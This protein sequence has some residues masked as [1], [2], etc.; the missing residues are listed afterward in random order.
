MKHKVHCAQSETSFAPAPG[1]PARR[2][3]MAL[4]LNFLS[5]GRILE[6]AL[7]VRLS[8]RKLA[9]AA[10]FICLCLGLGHARLVNA[11]VIFDNGGP[12]LT[13]FGAISDS[14]NTQV[15]ED[16]RLSAGSNI[17]TDVHWWGGYRFDESTPATDNFTI[18]I[19]ATNAVTNLPVLTPLFEFF[20]GD[21]GRTAIGTDTNPSTVYEYW[22]NIPAT[23]LDPDTT[24]WLSIVNTTAPFNPLDDWF[25]ERAENSGSLA[26]LT[27][28]FLNWQANSTAELA[29]N[30]TGNVPEPS[31][32]ALLALGLAGITFARRRNQ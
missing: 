3:G 25:W 2:T 16:F 7:A 27:S 4:G 6:E 9:V 10:A 29:F 20:V 14:S 23:P 30:L 31:T 22:V 17:V 8:I 32:L 19:L 18:R 13:L 15:A 28:P 5:F 1:A 21:V 11:T 24:F 26:T 12:R